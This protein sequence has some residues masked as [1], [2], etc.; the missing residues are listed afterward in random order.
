MERSS[1]EW[2]VSKEME[3]SSYYIHKDTVQEKPRK[4]PNLTVQPRVRKYFKHLL[5]HQEDI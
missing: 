4:R 2:D 3:G 1:R 5:K